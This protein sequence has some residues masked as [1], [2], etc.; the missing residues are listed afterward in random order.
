MA[1]SRY[2]ISQNSDFQLLSWKMLKFKDFLNLLSRQW[3][4]MLNNIIPIWFS[5][6]AVNPYTNIWLCYKCLSAWISNFVQNL[7]HFT[8]RPF[9]A[10]LLNFSD[11][12]ILLIRLPQCIRLLCACL[13][14]MRLGYSLM[15][16]SNVPA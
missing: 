8:L 4:S 3:F 16:W 5:K 2:S 1:Y 9:C 14:I 10:K 7:M 6:F 15:A 13:A 11:F 12:Y